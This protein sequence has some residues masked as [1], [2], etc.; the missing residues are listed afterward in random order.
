[1]KRKTAPAENRSAQQAV[2]EQRHETLKP[3][4]TKERGTIQDRNARRSPLLRLPA[5]L[6][7]QIWLYAFG[8]R[9]IHPRMYYTDRQTTDTQTPRK[10]CCSFTACKELF[11]D[12]EVN[13]GAIVVGSRRWMI[14]K[15]QALSASTF[16]GSHSPCAK[17]WGIIYTIVPTVCKQI[18]YE[19]APIAYKTCTFTF[20]GDIDFQQFFKLPVIPFDLITKLS[21]VLH[22]RKRHPSWLVG[23]EKAGLIAQLKSLK[24]LNIVQANA[25][26][27]RPSVVRK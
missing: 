11:T 19:A 3:R 6:R 1:M 16:I 22:N 8:S 24:S 17:T 27:H 9:A 5:E 13:R 4:L 23:L 18:Y 26:G 25:Y 2:Q 14:A 7:E 15:T 20:D 12:E 10:L 21:I